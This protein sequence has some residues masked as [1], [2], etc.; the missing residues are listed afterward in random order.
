MLSSTETVFPLIPQEILVATRL[1]E[2]LVSITLSPK[3]ETELDRNHLTKRGELE[4][5]G[6]WDKFMIAVEH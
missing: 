4:M 1:T 2:L 3:T 5:P 6:I